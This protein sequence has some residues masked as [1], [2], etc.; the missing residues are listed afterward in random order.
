VLAAADLTLANLETTVAPAT[1]RVG[2]DLG[3]TVAARAPAYG[4]G[5]FFGYPSFNAPPALLQALAGAG[6]DV[7]V[8]A[9]NHA[10]DRR[11]LGAERTL[12]QVEAA[13]LAAI[14]TR[15]RGATTWPALVRTL[16]GATVAI[17]AC[18]DLSNIRPDADDVL[19]HCSDE[20]PAV[21]AAIAEARTDGADAVVVFAHWGAEYVTEPTPRQRKL[22]RAFAAAG[23]D[24]VVGT[25]PHVVQPIERLT[26]TRGDASVTVPVAYSLGNFVSHQPSL[27][28]RT[29]ALLLIDV[30]GPA[31]AAVPAP[32]DPAPG[33][34]ALTW[35]P[36]VVDRSPGRAGD[37]LDPTTEAP[38]ERF[39]VLA[40]G[41]PDPLGERGTGRAGTP[42][43]LAHLRT[44]LGEPD[45]RVTPPLLGQGARLRA[46]PRCDIPAP[47]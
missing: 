18:T 9:N 30:V 13:G 25:H 22:A 28:S 44:I 4:D 33:I 5:V 23:A 3:A 35:I 14:G 42:G 24:A 12:E 21:T 34:A 46:D 20:L 7:L 38:A 1:D 27:P 36:L 2:R 40:A 45:E 16:P 26:V 10:L 15:R 37:P 47:E 17:V 43:E 39:R 41:R 31:P 32:P 11:T 19:L 6:V 8:T 29:G